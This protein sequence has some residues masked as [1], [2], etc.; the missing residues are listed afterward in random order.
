M[1]SNFNF[2]INFYSLIEL[3]NKLSN[4]YGFLYWW[5]AN[6]PLEVIE[7]A[8]LAQ[9]T[10]WKNAEASVKN[11]RGLSIEL[12][13]NSE[14]EFLIPLIKEAGF[15]SRKSIYLRNVLSFYKRKIY[16]TPGIFDAREEL[17]KVKGIGRETAD[18]IALYAFNQRTFPVDSYT[19]RLFNRYFS[20]NLSLMDY[21]EVRTSVSNVF[22]TEMLREFHALIDEHS[23][24]ICKKNPDCNNCFLKENCLFQ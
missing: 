3:F 6:E 2:L 18:S 12:I 15:Y 8:I 9:N 23:K 16:D 20:L 4:F 22:D 13:I 14:N 10:S 7:G 19:I 1:R 11:L 5:P 17:L 24:R 21:E